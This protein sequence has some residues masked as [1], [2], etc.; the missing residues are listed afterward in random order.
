[1]TMAEKKLRVAFFFPPLCMTR[2]VDPASIWTSSRGL[3]GS[4]LSC[5]M[6][7]LGLAERGHSVTLFTRATGPGQVGD[8]TILH[9]DDWER[10]FKDQHWDALCSWM[11][12]QPLGLAKPD[13]FRFLNQQCSELTLFEPGWES[14]TDLFTPL[15]NSH[16]NYMADKTPFPKDRWRILH[17][18]VDMGAFAPGRKDPGKMIWASSHDRGLHWLLEA[19]PQI[20][21]RAPHANLHVFYNFEGIVQFANMDAATQAMS[22]TYPELSRRSRYTLEALARLEGNGVHVH[23]S[24]SRDRIR[25]EMAT[26]EVLA[27]PCDP[28][29]YTE[30]C[31]VTVLEACASGTVPVLCTADAFGELWGS[32][33]LNVPTPYEDHRGEFVEHVVNVL[34]DADLRESLSEECVAHARNFS[35]PAL[36]L[37]LEECLVSRGSAGLSG[38]EWDRPVPASGG[39]KLNIG[40]G[41]NIFPHPGWT[42]YDHVDVTD[43]L[44]QVRTMYRENLIEGDQKELGRFLV[45]E[46]VDFRIHDLRTGFL[47]HPDGS[48][49]AIYIGQVIEHLNPLHEAPQLLRECHRMLRPGGVVRLTTPDLDKLLR[50]YADGTMSM[51]ADEFPAFYA[52]AAPADQLSY[53]LYGAA[54]AS[55]TWD[56]YE[57]HM[58]MYNRDSMARLFREAGFKAPFFFYDSAGESRC[59]AMTGEVVD[60]G[61]GHSFASEAVRE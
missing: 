33:G 27:Y 11:V 48:V 15:S 61:M 59:P 16:A 1:M 26:S 5:V 20:K 42:N 14:Y 19:F 45:T 57:G 46:D 7:A 17:N 31:G 44:E 18:G 30:T 55:C 38:V 8:L 13:Q 49:D 23:E 25:K 56:H 52:D 39:T 34:T 60:A 22:P 9:Y 2:P 32:V 36:I 29:L 58:H 12:P 50:A 3:T 24:V 37:K 54:G 6:Y 40:S 28:V 21:Q 10:T 51:F 41:P 47:Q 43:Y 4:E 35:W 53:I